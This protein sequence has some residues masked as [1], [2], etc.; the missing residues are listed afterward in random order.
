MPESLKDIATILLYISPVILFA[1]WI[2]WDINKEETGSSRVRA[3]N[4]KVK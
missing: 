1:L 4:L 3:R 2:V